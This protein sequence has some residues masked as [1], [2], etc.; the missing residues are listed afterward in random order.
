MKFYRSNN[1]YDQQ[2]CKKNKCNNYYDIQKTIYK[3]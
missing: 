3:I 1:Y 2:Y